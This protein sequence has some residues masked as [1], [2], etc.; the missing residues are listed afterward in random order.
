MCLKSWGHNSYARVLV[1]VSS[2]TALLDS[3][4]V[5]IPYPNG[6]GH[7]F[8]TLEIEYEW[9][10]PRCETC[11]IFDHDDNGCPKRVKTVEKPV[12]NDDSFTAVNR[13]KGKG[14][15]TGNRHVD[16][17]RFQKPKVSFY[18]RPV[19]KTNADGASTSQANSGMSN[20][21]V[22][23][24]PKPNV[25]VEPEVDKGK[26]P[27]RAP[28]D[29]IVTNTQENQPV[30]EVQGRGLMFCVLK[31]SA[32]GIGL[33]MGIYVRKVLGLFCGGTKIRLILMWFPWM[34]RC[35]LWDN[36]KLHKHYVRYRPWCILGDFN[37]ALNLEDKLEGSSV[38][39][40]AMREFKECVDEIEVS[41]VN[42]SGL[43]FT[44]NQKPKGMD[45][46]SDL[47]SFPGYSY[48]SYILY[49]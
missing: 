9:K 15:Q 1:E 24:D 49:F 23:K 43:Q 3:I 5:A 38:I 25:L 40:I 34:T 32:I 33:L 36:L 39:D 14:K 41:D 8:E 26:N 17:V 18:Y 12:V 44:W 2:L 35:L 29:N 19:V 6:P 31:F 11:K 37:S 21:N 28:N 10:P 30:K 47:G 45:A 20:S 16:G 42:R 7:S 27:Q 46:L 4:V 48:Y 13:G 22:N